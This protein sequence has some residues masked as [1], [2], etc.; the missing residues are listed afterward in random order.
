M[1]PSGGHGRFCGLRADGCAAAESRP[2]PRQRPSTSDQQDGQDFF[3][4]PRRSDGLGGQRGARWSR[5]SPVRAAIPS[6][7]ASGASS[8]RTGISQLRRPSPRSSR[9][10]TFATCT[11]RSVCS[12]CWTF[13]AFASRTPLTRVTRSAASALPTTAASTRCSASSTRWSSRRT[14]P[15]PGVGFD[16]PQGGDVKRREVEEFMLA[17][18]TDLAPS[19]GQ[20]VTLEL[21]QP[22]RAVEAA[23]RPACTIA[24]LTGFNSQLARRQWR[25]NA[26]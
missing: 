1:I 3:L 21:H 16:G 23:H 7:P 19:V 25:G 26:S 14:S 4:G 10:R 24:S 6:T 22:Q 2:Q 20:Q 12:G 9:S 11:P 17:F 8:A 5:A 15:A 18:D 13:R